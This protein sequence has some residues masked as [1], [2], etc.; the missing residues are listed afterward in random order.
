MVDG[1]LWKPRSSLSQKVERKA[2]ANFSRGLIR[3]SST[4]VCIRG[5]YA[6]VSRGRVRDTRGFRLRVISVEAYWSSS[7]LRR[8]AHAHKSSR[9]QDKYHRASPWKSTRTSTLPSMF[10]NVRCDSS[11]VSLSLL[12]PKRIDF[13]VAKMSMLTITENLIL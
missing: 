1:E 5:A 11:P 2:R 12:S 6:C 9:K 8:S 10:W 13:V 4:R 3:C 7:E